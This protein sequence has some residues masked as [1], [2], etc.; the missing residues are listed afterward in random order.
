MGELEFDDEILETAVQR[1]PVL[2]VFA[3]EPRYRRELQEALDYSKA[4]C[5]RIIRSF[6]ERGLLRRTDDGYELT[7]LGQAVAAQVEAFERNIRTAYQLNPLLE[8]F[9]SVAVDFDVE[10]FTDATIVR[11]QPDDPSPPVHRYLELFR[12]ARSVRTL[13]RTS[14]VPPLYLDEIFE[15]AFTD[16]KKGGIVIYPKSVV[17]KRYAEYPEWHRKVAEQGIPLRYRI[18]DRSPFGMTIYDDDHVGLRAYDEETGTLV[19]FADTDNPA[20]LSWAEDVFD[21]YYERSEPLGAFDSF[22]DWV[23]DS[24][25]YDEIP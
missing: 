25:V 14:F 8:A 19:L 12:E 10:L 16:D 22:P 11:P 1:K 9:D 4:T 7:E 2:A 5:H 6:D 21:Y 15:T 17:E 20:A 3:E 24:D 23:P 18:Y 13:A